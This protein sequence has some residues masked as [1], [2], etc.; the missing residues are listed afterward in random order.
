MGAPSVTWTHY[1]YTWVSR[2]LY[3]ETIGIEQYVNNRLVT[4]MRYKYK[5]H[6]QTGIEETMRIVD[7]DEV[8]DII[9]VNQTANKLFIEIIA[10]IVTD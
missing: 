4:P 6:Y 9:M 7:E 10:Q 2:S 5:A 8:L 3:S 1:V